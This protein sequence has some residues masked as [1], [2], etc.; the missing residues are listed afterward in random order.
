MARGISGKPLKW[1]KEPWFP[2]EEQL[3]PRELF[4]KDFI[5]ASYRAQ[6]RAQ[7]IYHRVVKD[8]AE[9][10]LFFFLCEVLGMREKAGCDNDFVF[11]RC[12]EVQATANQNTLD[13]W[14]RGHFKSTIITFALTL[15]ELA[16]DPELTFMILSFNRPIAKAFLRQLKMEMETNKT[17]NGLWPNS[18]YI[19][20]NRQSP[21]WNE[22]LGLVVKR[23]QTRK[24]ASINA[25]GMIDSSPVSIHVDRLIIDDAVTESSVITPEMILRVKESFSLADNL[26]SRKGIKRVVGTRYHADDAYQ[27]LIESEVYHTRIYPATAD[28]TPLGE[29]VMLTREELMEKRR[30][31]DTYT[32]QCQM[33]LNPKREEGFGFDTEWLEY[34]PADNCENLNLYLLADPSGGE[35]KN[36]DYTAMVILGYGP[37]ENYYIVDMIRDHLGLMA[38]ASA[39]FEW[40]RKYKPRCVYY[41]D[42]GLKSDIA[43][44]KKRMDEENYR[45]RIEPLKPAG[46]KKERR[47]MALEP[48][49]RER[50]IFLPATC[51]RRLSNGRKVDVVKAFIN[52]EYSV[53]P[54]AKHD[55]MLDVLAYISDIEVRKPNRRRVSRSKASEHLVNL[56]PK[57]A[58]TYGAVSGGY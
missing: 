20:P 54:L 19:H 11:N 42:V 48:L 17:L 33:L 23:K 39:I 40:H 25:Y 34:W 57:T 58:G 8:F 49:F 36:A 46:R 12:N 4:W 38:R 5:L 6:R 41:E 56:V 52:E 18:F 45:F 27:G 26:L 7:P 37:D 50:R 24:E 30:T 55:D 2:P 3:T 21:L 16:K 29:P 28:G 44:F 51:M 31:Q 14:S 22:D 32:F 53:W 15:W 10:S 47:I 43:Y 35:S 13:L 1:D 9:K